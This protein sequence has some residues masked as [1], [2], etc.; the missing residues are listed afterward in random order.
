MNAFLMDA[1]PPDQRGR[2]LG[3]VGSAQTAAMAVGALAGGALFAAGLWVPF[4]ASLVVGLVLIFAAIP[5]L[6]AAGTHRRNLFTE[7]AAG[8]G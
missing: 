3:S 4:V 2:A 1:V 7:A 6:R 8:H 5:Q